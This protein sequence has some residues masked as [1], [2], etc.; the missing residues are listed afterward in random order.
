LKIYLVHPIS[1]YSYEETMAYFEPTTA[2]LEEAGY[3]VLCPMH[4]K[5]NLKGE[6]NLRMEGYADKLESN[7]H[8]IFRRDHWMAS[9][10]DIIYA[11]LLGGP[12]SVSIGCMFEIAW[13]F[14]MGKHTVMAM[15]DEVGSIY[16]HA[17]VLEAA[18]IIFKAHEDALAYLTRLN[19]RMV[20]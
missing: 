4:N 8:S 9:Q 7:G 10:A 11:N 5:E 14:E 19:E 3:D 15:N 2:A 6:T 20:L 13:G 12:R 18:D 17:F 16:R 1:G